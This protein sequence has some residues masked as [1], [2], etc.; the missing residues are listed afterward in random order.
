MKFRLKL[1]TI[2]FLSLCTQVIGQGDSTGMDQFIGDW[3]GE[4]HFY[5][6]NFSNEVGMVRF[7]LRVTT[8]MEISGSIGDA[9]L[10][11][12]EIE[13]DDWNDGFMIKG[14]VVGQI[15]PHND[16]Q[17]KR[18]IIML[19]EVQDGVSIGDFHLKSNFIFDF[20]MRPGGITLHKNP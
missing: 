20:N 7:T 5:N 12:A 19:N 1:M 6:V 3:Y 15:F 16:F 18:I 8:E 2:L 4:G 17:K 9:E 11:D 14:T 13:V 10:T